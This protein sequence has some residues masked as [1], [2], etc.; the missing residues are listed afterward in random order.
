MTRIVLSHLRRYIFSLKSNFPRIS[1]F[2][3]IWSLIIYLVIYGTSKAF[4][5]EEYCLSTGNLVESEKLIQILMTNYSRYISILGLFVFFRSQSPAESAIPVK[6]EITV[7]D[8]SELSVLSNSFTTD[9]W[10]R[11]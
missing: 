11:L 7:Q 4:E 8:I 6:V 1:H 2:K 10:F 9:L 3:M 5:L